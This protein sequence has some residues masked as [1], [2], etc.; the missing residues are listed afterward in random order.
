MALLCSHFL[1]AKLFL[2]READEIKFTRPFTM[3]TLAVIVA[4]NRDLPT[5]RSTCKEVVQGVLGMQVCGFY[6][7]LGELFR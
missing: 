2:N 1:R 3:A 5:S 4:R 7:S 6:P